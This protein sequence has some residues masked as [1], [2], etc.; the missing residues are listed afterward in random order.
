MT[1]PDA[2][3]GRHRASATLDAARARTESARDRVVPRFARQPRLVSAERRQQ[4]TEQL[5][6]GDYCTLCGMI[7]PGMSM[8]ACPR[9]ASCE[10]D[11]DGKLRAVTFWPDGEYDASGTYSAADVEE[12]D[13][14][15]QR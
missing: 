12:D 15:D 5:A 1:Y 10:M 14:A 8:P 9:V 6:A 11:A 2:Q 4:I 13:G 3:A 7:H